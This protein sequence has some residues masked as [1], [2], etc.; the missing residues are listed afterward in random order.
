MEGYGQTGAIPRIVMGTRLVHCRD[1]FYACLVGG[2][3]RTRRG[4]SVRVVN[5][6]GCLH[7]NNMIF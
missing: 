1:A 5:V 4:V 3:V 2:V 7:V 6:L